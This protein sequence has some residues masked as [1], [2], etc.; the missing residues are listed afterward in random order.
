[1]NIEELEGEL[2]S[3]ARRG[4][5]LMMLLFMSEVSGRQPILSYATPLIST[6]ITTKYNDLYICL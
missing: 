2:S 6:T 1:M 5:E 4:G 3:N